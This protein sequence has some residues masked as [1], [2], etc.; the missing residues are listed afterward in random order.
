MF[1]QPSEIHLCADIAGWSEIASLDRRKHCVSRSRKRGS[2]FEPDWDTDLRVKDFSY[3]LK[4][5]GF[6]FSKRGVLFCTIYDKTRE[7]KQSG[8]EWF[9]DIWRLHGWNEDDG[10][11]WRI[12]FKFK[13]QALHELQQED[14]FWGIENA[15]DLPER[16]PVLWAYAAGRVQ[17]SDNDE[18]ADGWL[19]CVVPTSN[20]NRARW[21]AHPVW[22][23]IQTAFIDSLGMPPQ[24]GKIVRKWW[25]E[26]NI[27]KGIEAVMGYLTSLAAWVGGDLAED[28][29]DLSVVL[30]WLVGIG[31]DYLERVGR[32]FS[33]EV[34]RKRIKFGL[35]AQ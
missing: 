29:V 4:E 17:G 23:L 19:R 3:G 6:D 12:E 21:S 2:H 11:V 15:F 32:D 14:K 5:T 34:Q 1:L 13:R 26:Q 18:L 27:N 9:S 31:A 7:M 25:E 20:K 33:A 22:Q 35:Q 24:F 30:H 8:K 16:L 28:G 10:T